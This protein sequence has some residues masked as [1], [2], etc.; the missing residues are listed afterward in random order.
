MTTTTSASMSTATVGDHRI[1]YRD[2]GE[3]EPVVL[4]HG[5]F[6]AEL[7]ASVEQSSALGG[8]RRVL[9]HRRGYGLSPRPDPVRPLTLADQADD[10]VG[11]LDHL[12]LGSAHVVGHSVGALAALTAA[13]SHRDRIESLVLVE[14]PVPLSRPAGTEWLQAVLPTVE[15]YAAADVVGAVDGF[16]DATCRE[17]WRE[18]MDA[19]WP[20][21]HG[22]SVAG[23]PMA[24]ESDLP[25]LE[26]QDGLSADQ[27]A[28]VRCPVHLV[29][30]G[31]TRPVFLEFGQV[32]RDWFPWYEATV[33]PGADHGVPLTAPHA[34]AE[35][36]ADV[37]RRTAAD[38]DG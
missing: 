8:V 14:P 25:G 11:L 2:T 20:T 5:G 18:R 37:V 3:G 32:V 7:L 31:S 24:Y 21:A 35:V 28:A 19:A 38:R 36:V 10:L 13:A 6:A 1:A 23:A 33:V 29:V 12:G 17:G 27:V 30:G 15:L 22:D 9:Y 34:V 4:V 26:W 16:Y